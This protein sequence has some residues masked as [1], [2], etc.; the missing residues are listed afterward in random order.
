[1]RDRL[2]TVRGYP[3]VMLRKGPAYQPPEAREPAQAKIVW[4]HGRR[5]MQLQ[6]AGKMALVGPLSGAGDLVG[7]CVFTVPADEARALMED[8]IAVRA[9]VFVYDVVTWYEFPGDGLPPA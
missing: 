7:L 6:A 2:A 9:G 1:M 3:T 4:E 5:N 8:D